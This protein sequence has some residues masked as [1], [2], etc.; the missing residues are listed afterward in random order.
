MD[1]TILTTL[2]PDKPVR[3]RMPFW[4]RQSSFSQLGRRGWTGATLAGWLME[5]CN[6]Q[7]HNHVIA[8]G[9]WV[10]PQGCGVMGSDTD[11]SASLMHFASQPPSKVSESVS[12]KQSVNHHNH[13]NIGFMMSAWIR[14][15]SGS[16]RY[17]SCLCFNIASDLDN[18]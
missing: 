11:Y 18:E 16:V 13:G 15:N 10:L 3:T 8:V 4:P 5:L 1:G 17:S 14:S 2:G 9:V 6:T 7:S 12:N